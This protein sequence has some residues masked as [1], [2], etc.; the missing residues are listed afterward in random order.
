MTR[1]AL[2]DARIVARAEVARDICVFEIE[3]TGA[4]PLPAIE[5]GAHIDVHVSGFVRQY[6]LLDGPSLVP[7]RYRIAVLRAASSRGGSEAMHAQL[8]EGSVLRISAPRNNF[9]LRPDSSSSVLVAGGIGITPIMSMAAA[10]H[11]S[12]AHFA[13]HYCARSKDRMAFAGELQRA[14]FAHAVHLYTDDE[15]QSAFDSEAVFA[16]QPSGAHLYVCGPQGFMDHVLGTAR[17]AGWDESRLHHEYF[18]PAAVATTSG[19]DRGF[20]LIAARSGKRVTVAAAETALQAL[21]RCGIEVAS[22]CEQGVCGSCLTPVL[23]GIV[24]HRDSFLTL[25]EKVRNEAFLPCC[26]RA[27]GKTLTVDL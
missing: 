23:E 20:E 6:S 26:S 11:A 3:A 2:I 8:R 10:L 1:A 22:S 14:P 18:Q 17:A 15:T 12:G 27:H 19:V 4:A 21:T 5:A 9:P 16:S 13:L 7:R 24:D 25:Q